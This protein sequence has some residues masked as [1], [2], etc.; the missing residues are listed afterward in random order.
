VFLQTLAV[1]FGSLCIGEWH[2]LFKAASARPCRSP[3]R[4]STPRSEQRRQSA[5]SNARGLALVV[6]FSC[7][8]V[9][10]AGTLLAHEGQH[11][12]RH[13]HSHAAHARG[14]KQAN[15]ADD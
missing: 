7:R 4:R 6:S 15:P 5:F 11:L 8:E 10:L 2:P 14:R 1:T 3:T 12:L 13:Q 9:S